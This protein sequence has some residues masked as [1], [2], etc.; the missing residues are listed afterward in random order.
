MSRYAPK[1]V[2]TKALYDRRWFLIGWLLGFAFLSWFVGVF[3]STFGSSAA[4]NEQF[5]SLPPS[6]KA[7]AGMTSNFNTVPG[8]FGS[9][10]FGKTM[11]MVAAILGIMLGTSLA[12][13]EEDGTLQTLLA[14]P[15]SRT[16]VFISKWLAPVVIFALLMVGLG[17]G[18][19][20]SLWQQNLSLNLTNTLL[21]ILNTWVFMVFFFS[22]TYAVGAAW[23]RRGLA[24][25]VGSLVAVS[26]YLLNTMAAGVES[27]KPYDV[28]SVYHYYGSGDVLEK[29]LHLGNFSILIGAIIV[30]LLISGFVFARRNIAAA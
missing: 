17:A 21:A 18:L 28:L 26:G 9:Q 11:P 15:L 14:A 7:V 29:G 4:L 25:G 2:L 8:Y 22:L 19:A 1:S 16:K 13:E 6:L 27:L 3:Y 23:G 30:S 24:I 5:Q 10:I 12:S 20:I